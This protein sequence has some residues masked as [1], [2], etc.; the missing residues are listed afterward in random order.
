MK[1][2]WKGSLQEEFHAFC[3]ETGTEK[4]INYFNKYYIKSAEPWFEAIRINKRV[5]VTTP[6]S[7]RTWQNRE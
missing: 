4:G 1:T 2:C 6:A 3:L 5:M 7:N